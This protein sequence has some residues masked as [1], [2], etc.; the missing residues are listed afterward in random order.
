MNQ[1]FLFM[2]LLSDIDANIFSRF[3]AIFPKLID[4]RRV[5]RRKFLVRKIRTS[6]VLSEL[7]RELLLNCARI[8]SAIDDTNRWG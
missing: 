8:I 5:S 7:E 2:L 1:I 6:I 3:S 4:E